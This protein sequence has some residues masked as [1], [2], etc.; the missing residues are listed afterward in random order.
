MVVA[1]SPSDM[2][3]AEMVVA[4]SPS[5]IMKAEMVVTPSREGSGP[6]GWRQK[7]YP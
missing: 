5:D 6:R 1:P 2:M 3:K 7:L 4:P